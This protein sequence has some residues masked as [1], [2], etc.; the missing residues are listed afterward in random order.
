MDDSVFLMMMERSGDL[1]K[2]ASYA[3]LFANVHSRHW[4]VNLIEFD[5]ARSF[6]HASYYVQK[7]F[8]ENRPDVNLAT[9]LRVTPEPDPRAPLMAGKFGLG[10]WHTV[11]EFKELRMYDEQGKLVFSDDFQDLNRWETPGVGR[12]QAAERVLRRRVTIT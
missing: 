3:P 12:W 1:V 8:N 7:A 5:A 6:A 11:S 9:T 2:M 10:S 4:G